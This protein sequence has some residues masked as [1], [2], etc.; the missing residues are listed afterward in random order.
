MTAMLYTPIPATIDRVDN[1]TPTIKTFG[2][3]PR[4][5][6]AFAAGQFV[7]LTVPGIGEAPFTPSSSPRIAERM[8][9]T[10]IKT[11][12][13]TDCLHDL[14]AGAEV[15]VRGPY[16]R[17]YPLDDFK[18]KKI[19]LAG[20]AIAGN[21]WLGALSGAGLWLLLVVVVIVL[22]NTTPRLR[23]D[24]AVKFFWGPVSAVAAVAVVLALIGW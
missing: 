10:I 1:E 19:L 4:E 11:G 2:I 21:G 24:Q 5:P 7:E 9:I 23:I 16:G 13:V 12:R 15:G 14:A 8:E 6:M 22:R 20:G 17:A 3:R 18:G